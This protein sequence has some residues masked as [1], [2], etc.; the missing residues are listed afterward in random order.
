[1]AYVDVDVHHGDGVMYGFYG[2]GR[3]LDID[4][5]QDGRTLFPGTGAIHET[6]AGDG[7]GLKVNVPLPPGAGDGAL[8]PIARRIVPPLLD[9]FRPRLLVVQHGVDGHWGDP[10]AGLRYTA[11]GYAEVDRLLLEWAERAECPVVLTGGGGYRAASVAR[12]LARAGRLLA[13]LP[14]PPDDAPL[15]EEWREWFFQAVGEPAPARWVDPAP[16][17]SWSPERGHK[18]VRTLEQALGRRFPAP[19][20]LPD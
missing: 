11:R 19:G 15:A 8:V 17:D 16:R 2:S 5:H 10:L 13:G 18:L 3:V 14:L 20:E 6:G 1:V 4:F 12:V 7:S 9:A